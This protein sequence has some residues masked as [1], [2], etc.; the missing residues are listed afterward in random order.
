MNINIPRNNNNNN[1]KI[2]AKGRKK[3]WRN[4]FHGSRVSMYVRSTLDSKN[5]WSKYFAQMLNN[6]IYEENF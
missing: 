1:N 2:C 4:P 6:S 5:T 3:I